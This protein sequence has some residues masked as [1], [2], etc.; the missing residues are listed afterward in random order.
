MIWYNWFTSSLC[1]QTKT[2][3]HSRGVSALILPNKV[4][5]V[6]RGMAGSEQAP[7]I[8]GVKLQNGEKTKDLSK[9]NMAD[10]MRKKKT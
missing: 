5:H 9:D 10:S 8:D 4:A 6:T 2:C 7:H 1:L 3:E